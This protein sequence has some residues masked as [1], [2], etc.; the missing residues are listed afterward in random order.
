ML[1]QRQI[2]LNNV[3][4]TSSFPMGLE[5][6]KAEGLHIWDI[7]KK[8][9]ID[10]IAGIS[11]SNVGHRHPT[12]IKAI[13]KQLGLYMHLMVYGEYIQ[14][15]QLELAKKI[16]DLLPSSLDNVFFVNSGSEAIEGAMKLAKRFTGRQEIIAFTNAYHGSTQGAL[17]LSSDE[18]RKLPFKPLLPSIQ[19]IDLNESGQLSMITE[20]TACVI[21]EPIQGEAGVRESKKSF[22]TELRNK[23]NETQ[24]LLIFDEIQTGFGRTGKMFAFEHYDIVPDIITFAKGMGGGM[25]IGAFVSS[26]E[27]MQTLTFEPVLG[28]ISTFGGHPV[29]CASAIGCIDALVE[30]NMIANIDSKSKIFKEKLSNLSIVKDYRSKG[31]LIAVEFDDFETNKRIIDKCIENGVITDWF[32]FSP[33]SMRIAPP[34]NITLDECELACELVIKSL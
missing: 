11:V 10:L 29:C 30:E 14:T 21:I 19:W 34:L 22:M 13:E 20:E 1:T 23:C 26:K 18:S 25:P 28:H 7:N 32:L 3:A 5:I 31:L 17:S 33:Q 2:F 15:P 9:Y 27:I 4:Q 8:K 12:V 6:E 24:T 16:T